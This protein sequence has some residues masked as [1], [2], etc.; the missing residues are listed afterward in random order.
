MRHCSIS[1]LTSSVVTR[2]GF[3][4][5]ELMIAVSLSMMVMYTAFSA[6][7]VVGQSVAATRR[8]SLENG[9]LRTGF[10]AALN[11][12]D[13][14]DMYDDRSAVPASAN[15]LRA[16]GK[17]FAPLMNFDPTRTPDDRETWWRGFGFAQ[18]A[19]TTLRWGNYGH[20]AHSGSMP[21]TDGSV[22]SWYPKQIKNIR[23]SIGAYGMLSYMPGNAIFGWFDPP[24][25]GTAYVYNGRPQDIWERTAHNHNSDIPLTVN[26]APYTDGNRFDYLPQRP[27]H[28]PGLRVEAR[29]YA[30]WSGFI[31][32]CQ[33][34]VQSPMTGETTR[35]SFWGVGTTL[36]GARQQRNLDSVPSHLLV[37]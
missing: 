19:A 37:P 30:V 25:S 12:L 6:F 15:P 33:I 20:L 1:H 18:D 35:L 17:P 16:P 7:R 31:D 3:T 26:G 27:M 10:M 21:G 22:R 13:Y 2:R 28:W 32:L 11:E 4:L 23:Q 8:L 36:R 34:E 5:I 24:A 29:R 14:W 9:M